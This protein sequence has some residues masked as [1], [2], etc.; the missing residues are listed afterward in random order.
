[1]T[2]SKSKSNTIDDVRLLDLKQVA[3]VVG[4]SADTINHWVRI[5]KFPRPMQ[6][7]PGA[8]KQWRYHQVAAWIEKR[9]RARYVK[10]TP[11]GR[12]RQ[13]AEHE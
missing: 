12:L 4:R 9:A 5:G 7:V 6:A 8:K 1:M 10:P 11:R 2:A 3:T 13:Y